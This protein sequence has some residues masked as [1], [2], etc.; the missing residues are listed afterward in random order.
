MKDRYFVHKVTGETFSAYSE[1]LKLYKETMGEVLPEGS[2]IMLP[3]RQELIESALTWFEDE[4]FFEEVYKN[5]NLLVN[6]IR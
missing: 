4:D 3:G 6:N 1:G 5:S 2:P